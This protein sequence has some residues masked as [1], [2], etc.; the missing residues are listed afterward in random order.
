[1]TY[2]GF[3]VHLDDIPPVLRWLSGNIGI[4]HVHHL[5]SRVPFYRLPQVL[6]EHPELAGIGRVTVLQSLKGVK[7]VLWDEQARRRVS[8][9]DARAAA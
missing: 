1:M 7:L 6:A 9:R 4:H 8:F 5:S 3:F 2:A